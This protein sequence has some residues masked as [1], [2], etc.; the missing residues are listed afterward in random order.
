MSNKTVAASN[1]KAT[2]AASK[3]ESLKTENLKPKANCNRKLRI[4]ER[5]E[6]TR[7]KKME[8]NF[9]LEHKKRDR[10]EIEKEVEMKK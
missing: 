10:N 1:Q 8:K 4:R 5:V 2:L 3:V 6:T 9:L 7:I